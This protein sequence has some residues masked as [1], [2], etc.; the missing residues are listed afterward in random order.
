MAGVELLSDDVAEADVAGELAVVELDLSGADTCHLVVEWEGAT[1][2]N[3]GPPRGTPSSVCWLKLCW[4]PWG[5]NPGPSVVEKTWQ[6]LGY[7]PARVI[8]LTP[9]VWNC[10]LKLLYVSFWAEKGW[11]LAP[12]LVTYTMLL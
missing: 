7:Q 1:W 8:V 5:L 11:G 3:Q 9:I 4:S 10:Y 12:A 2:P 6:G